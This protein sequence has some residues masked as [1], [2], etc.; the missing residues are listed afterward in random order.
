M[1]FNKNQNTV[2]SKL[3]TQGGWLYFQ[4]LMRHFKTIPVLEK[5]ALTYF[6]YMIKTNSSKFDRDLRREDVD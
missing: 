2:V 1:T 4:S 3:G 5:E 6:I